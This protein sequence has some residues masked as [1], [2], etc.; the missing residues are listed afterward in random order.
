METNTPSSISDKRTWAEHDHCHL[1]ET[2]RLVRAHARGD[3]EAWGSLFRRVYRP[4]CAFVASWLGPTHGDVDDIAQEILL[5][6][7]QNARHYRGGGRGRSW[8][9]GIGANLLRRRTRAETR[10]L[11]AHALLGARTPPSLTPLELALRRQDLRHLGKA[12]YDLPAP[13]RQIV[14]IVHLQEHTGPQA[15]ARLDVP[16][17]TVWRRL[18]DARLR[19]RRSLSMRDVKAP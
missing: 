6:V 1:D 12:I 14:E 4:V 10:R 17:G 13:L 9:F 19:L 7:G 5:C 18:H 16:Q 8:I 3:P 11:R 2:A 15:A